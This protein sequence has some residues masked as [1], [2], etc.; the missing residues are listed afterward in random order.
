[1]QEQVLQG[2]D[3]GR[4]RRQLTGSASR[5]EARAIVRDRQ[6]FVRGGGGG[7][8]A[9]LASLRLVSVCS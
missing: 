9:V 2:I 6:L 1:V 4:R 5:V 3:R 7:R 8:H